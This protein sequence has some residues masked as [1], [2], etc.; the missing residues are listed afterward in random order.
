[1]VGA[2]RRTASCEDYTGGA[3]KS[4]LVLRLLLHRH[5]LARGYGAR[6]TTTEEQGLTCFVRHLD[7]GGQC[8][9]PGTREVHGLPLCEV[10]GREAELGAG[11]ESFE[12]ANYFFE[13]FRNPH[14]PQQGDAIERT[15][16]FALD[17]LREEAPADLGHQQALMDAYPVISEDARKKVVRW[18]FDQSPDELPVLDILLSDLHAMHKLLRIAFAEEMLW[19][20]EVLEEERQGLAVQAAFVLRSPNPP[21]PDDED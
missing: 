9:E 17:R 8:T 2:R 10:H 12:D 3:A 18:I 15:L 20:V 5:G 13:R 11:L 6:T 7:A 4:S 16:E 19:L 1:M 21:D 14:V